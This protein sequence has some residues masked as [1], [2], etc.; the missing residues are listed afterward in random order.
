[1][2][3]RA[4]YDLA[5]GRVLAT[6][7]RAESY[8]SMLAMA[9]TKLKFQNP[10]NNTWVLRAAD[11]INTGSGAAKLAEKAKTYLQ[12]VVDEH[13]DTPWAMLAK[14]ELSEPIGWKW[15]ETFRQPP[16][17]PQPRQNNGNNNVRR[18]R[19]PQPAPKT[20]RPPPKL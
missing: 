4:G 3:W 12:R 15:D 19:M 17:P 5:M 11:E 7:I 13:P 20:K 10:K 1:M 14:R 8:N 16:Q 2:R 18:Q 6:K 9:K